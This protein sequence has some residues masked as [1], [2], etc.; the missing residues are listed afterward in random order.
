MQSKLYLKSE[1]ELG[2]EFYFSIQFKLAGASDK[3]V[4]QIDASIPKSD[5]ALRILIAEDNEINLLL[6]RLMIKNSFPNAVILEA[7]NGL[8]VIE[9]YQTVPLDLILM[10]IQMPLKNGYETTTE[11]RQI[12]LSKRTPIIALTAGILKEEKQK[13]LDLGMDDYISKPINSEELHSAILKVVNSN[14]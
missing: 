11:I 1:P 10:D 5:R 7:R 12:E 4:V 14:G 2:S 8:E 6:V 9:I 3:A 13:C